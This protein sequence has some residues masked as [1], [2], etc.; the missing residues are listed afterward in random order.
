MKKLRSDFCLDIIKFV[1]EGIEFR[2][3]IDKQM[4]SAENI[5]YGTRD[6]HPLYEVHFITKGK[7]VLE[8]EGQVF[9]L[10]KNDYCIIKPGRFHSYIKHNESSEEMFHLRFSFKTINK[11][12]ASINSQ[13]KNFLD[14][15]QNEESYVVGTMN[16][17]VSMLELITKEREFKKAFYLKSVELFVT[18]IFIFIARSIVVSNKS[19]VNSGSGIEQKYMYECKRN[20]IIDSFFSNNYYKKDLKDTDLAEVLNIGRRQLN[21]V[22]NQLYECSFRKYL[23]KVRI[24]KSKLLLFSSSVSVEEIQDSCGF[25]NA[26]Y[27]YRAFKRITGMTPGQCRKSAHGF[28]KMPGNTIK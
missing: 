27:F 3:I 16:D 14:L 22:L 4:I 25:S 18:E 12:K 17:A 20:Y 23:L 1:F 6:S 2:V 21:R 15:L 9:F 19:D 13:M 11:E 8:V 26:E 10:E 7:N 28:L 5:I 24:E